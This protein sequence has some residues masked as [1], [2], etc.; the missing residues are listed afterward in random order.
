MVKNADPEAGDKWEGPI[1]KI[2]SPLGSMVI[3][4]NK[5]VIQNV[6]KGT[7][8]C[9]DFYPIECEDGIISYDTCSTGLISCDKKTG[10]CPAF[11]DMNAT[12]KDDQ[13]AGGVC[14]FISIFILFVCLIGL[15]AVLQK[16]LLGV[17]TRIIYKATNVNGYLAM[18]IGA[19]ITVI[20][21]SSSITTSALTPLVGVGVLRLEQMLP[22][23]LGANIGTTMT[24]I[25]AAMVSDGTGA[26]QV[27]LAHL[28]FNIT[29]II[30]WYP[31]PF[32]RRVPLAGARTLGKA[33]RLWRGFPLVYIFFVFIIIPA[34]F[35]G[36]SALFEQG[37]KGWTT[38]GSFLTIMIGGGLIYTAYWWKY[39]DGR[40]SCIQCFTKRQE[41][42]ET[43]ESL[44][45]DMRFLK[46]TVK[47]LVDHTGL[48]ED[49]IEDIEM[50]AAKGTDGEAVK[51]DS[52]AED[53]NEDNIGSEIQT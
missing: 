14:F 50:D 53:T 8:N 48:P 13:V 19:G 26:L 47:A 7:D 17:S 3:I 15:V 40:N 30:I 20:V 18:L 34:I 42:K 44:P 46:S 5:K 29:G 32:M 11:F 52:A 43:M 38:L 21:Q 25:M 33:T 28:F 35:L 36:L 10:D 12:Q 41:R 16:M 22:L 1:K 39:K 23:T 24:A 4:A 9:T 6:A 31:I 49:D 27:A 45:E 2:V 37:N 51:N